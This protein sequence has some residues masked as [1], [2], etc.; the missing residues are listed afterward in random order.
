MSESRERRNIFGEAAGD[1]EAVR[2][3]YPAALVT[4]L[5]A[6][7][8]PGPVLEVGAG[9]GKATVA[10]A[11]HG[12]E[13]VCLEPDP[14]MAAVLSARELPRV[15]VVTEQF[16]TWAP[17]RRFGLV[18]CAQAWHWID[19]GKRNDRA[20]TALAPGGLLALFWNRFMT[21][22]V[23]LH[24][25]LAE[26]DREFFPGGER[27]AHTLRADE[28]PVAEVEFAEE[29]EGLAL[30][31]DARFTDPR[32]RNYR[33]T[34]RYQAADYARFLGTTSLYRMLEP[35]ARDQ[36]LAAVTA[37]VEAHG[38]EIEIAVDTALATARRV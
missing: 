2:P 30:H 5:L 32:N 14:R 26:I 27:T 23:A 12:V 37:A 16:E 10:F 20:A 19:A 35:A 3:G 28:H 8:G 11:A 29:W 18:F 24:A 31:D 15:S 33:W 17:G 25:A 36:V 34:L 4:D 7:A 38:G 9:T 13:L 21:T 6:E 22:G 1:Y